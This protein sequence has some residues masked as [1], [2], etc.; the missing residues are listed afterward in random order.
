MPFTSNPKRSQKKQRSPQNGDL[1]AMNVVI[2]GSLLIKCNLQIS[3]PNYAASYLSLAAPI[4]NVL[5]SPLKNGLSS[6]TATDDIFNSFR[7]LVI[8]T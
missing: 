4:K 7:A 2:S 6:I 1:S 5:G 3:F 8:A